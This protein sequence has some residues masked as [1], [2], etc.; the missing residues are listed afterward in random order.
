MN[1]RTEQFAGPTLFGTFVVLGVAF[2]IV[3]KV[4]FALSPW[5]ALGVPVLIMVAYAL[6]VHLPALRLRDDQTGDNL[7]YMG[8]LFT[9]TSLGVALYQFSS[10]GSA[11]Q[12]VRA[13]GIAIAS[14]IAGIAMRILFAQMRKDPVEVE[15]DARLELA[16]AARR[17]RRELDATVIELSNFRRHTTQSLDDGFKDVR[18]RVEN[19]STSLLKSVEEIVERSRNPLIDASKASSELLG[20]MGQTTATK[21]DGFADTMTANLDKSATALAS[22]NARLTQSVAAMA[23]TLDGMAKKLHDMQTPEKVIEVK[24]E[25]V[26]QPIIKGAASFSRNAE[27]AAAAQALQLEKS[28]SIQTSL[29]ALTQNLQELSARLSQNDKVQGDLSNALTALS[30]VLTEGF[31]DIKAG[32]QASRGD[33]ERLLTS[34]EGANRSVA[35]EIAALSREIRNLQPMQPAGAMPTL[36]R[37]EEYPR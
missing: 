10:E 17:V 15:R 28:E 11:E 31:A 12:I 22:E 6:I 37:T 13:F 16:E 24:L 30:R 29:A 25:P 21:L 23:Q 9:L 19:I 14:T 33:V 2:I 1:A 27:R 7:Y 3:A 8:F 36:Q 32:T 5:L 26:L 20:T 4:Q 18:T 34:V 35:S